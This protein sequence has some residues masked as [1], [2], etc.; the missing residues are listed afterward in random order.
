MIARELCGWAVCSCRAVLSMV[1]VLCAFEA[2]AEPVTD[3]ALSGAQIVTRNECA[4]LKISF[5]F[6]VRY[7]SHFPLD[8]GNELRIRV[9][10]ID[11]AVAAA[12]I[13]TQRES[14][15][16]PGN[17]IAAIKAIEL[18]LN[19]APGPALVIQFNRTVHYE[20]GQGADFQSVIVAIS[21]A[22]KSKF[23]RPI[24]PQTREDSWSA[25]VRRESS[26]SGWSPSVE[27]ALPPRL[28]ARGVGTLTDEDRRAAAAAMDE[29]RAALKKNKPNEAIRRLSKVLKLPEN[30]HSAEAQELIG[31]ARQRSGDLAEAQAEYEDYLS[32]YPQGDGADRVRQRLAGVST[33]KG[34]PP[35][36]VAND[37]TAD[38]RRGRFHSGTDGTSAWTLSGSASQFYIRDDSFRVLHD[39]SLPPDF[40]TNADDHA[41]HQNELLSSFDLVGTWSND[42]SKWKFRFS[43]SEEHYFSNDVD[44]IYALAALY[45]EATVRELDTMVRVGRQTRNTDGVLGRFDGALLSWQ[46]QPWMALNLV[47]GSPVARRRDEPFKDEKYFYGASV[48]IGPFF[49]GLDISLFGIEQRDRDWIDRQGIGFE[50]RYLTP[51]LASFATVDYDVHFGELNAAIAS[52]TWTFSDK[53]TLHG[54]F[55]YR[56]SPYLSAWTAIQGQ[57]FITLYDLLKLHTI[58]E[59]DQLAIDRTATYRAASIGYSRFL[60][61]HLQAS[62]DVTISDTTGTVA[63]GGVAALP[64]T[65]M[66][67]YYSAQL[68]ANDIIEANDMYIVGLRLAA[69]ELSNLYVL[70]FNSLYPI[71]EDL[72]VGPRLRLGYRKGNEED[73]T[74]YTVLPS[75]LVDYYWTRD[76]S[77]E[78]EVGVN[79][80]ETMQAGVQEDNTELFVTAGFRYDFYADGVSNCR[81]P[82]TICK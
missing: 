59:A 32:R 76:F 38:K 46:A 40:N 31:L 7:D 68:I 60:T 75:V 23:C 52:G 58:E 35:A 62:A 72:R 78:L 63:S 61:E 80:T 2:R 56:K 11:P 64:A 69:G 26:G 25:K 74:E 21:G 57:P 41:V 18:D 77:L 44:E 42:A 36:S 24:L 70:D 13:L 45:L 3:R 33:A 12:N 73:L 30:E 71:R 14:L 47:A 22:K 49:D 20:V 27:P 28:K 67:T 65:G 29:A 10:A 51:S 34:E 15:R 50:V 37:P 43:G 79:W 6:R 4:L 17:K 53:S 82:G 9:S 5:N 66:D 48:D 19:F 1:A 16:A 54:G 39:P 8:H 81:L 55:E